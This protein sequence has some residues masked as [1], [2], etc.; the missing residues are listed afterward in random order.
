MNPFDTPLPSSFTKSVEEAI[1]ELM[2]DPVWLINTYLTVL[3]VGADN[4][5]HMNMTDKINV[6]PLVIAAV[7]RMHNEINGNANTHTVASIMLAFACG[8]ASQKYMAEISTVQKLD[9][10]PE[11]GDIFDQLRG[12]KL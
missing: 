10:K 6:V 4:I 11:V 7:N 8:R 2:K 5:A 12:M 9:Y 1:S 3:A